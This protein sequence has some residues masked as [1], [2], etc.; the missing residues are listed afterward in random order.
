M[1]LARRIFH[2]TGAKRSANMIAFHQHSNH[3]FLSALN[4]ATLQYVKLQSQDVIT[5]D[6][7]ITGAKRSANTIVFHQHSLK[8]STHFWHHKSSVCSCSEGRTLSRLHDTN[9]CTH[10]PL[11]SIAQCPPFIS[12]D[13]GRLP[14]RTF[15]EATFH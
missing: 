6:F 15:C 8:C 9:A 2:I 1:T 4:D 13:S 5:E 10:G 14:P 3:R 7:H 11:G 12:F